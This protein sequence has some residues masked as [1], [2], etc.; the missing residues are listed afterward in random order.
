MSKLEKLIAKNKRL[1]TEAN[2]VALFLSETLTKS[3]MVITVGDASLEF[4][5]KDAKVRGQVIAIMEAE[6]ER[7]YA[8]ASAVAKK[9]N[10]LETLV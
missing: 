9:V 7:L 10:A 8:E 6:H 4:E 5:A 1:T 2:A 3:D